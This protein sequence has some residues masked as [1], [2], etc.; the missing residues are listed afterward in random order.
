MTPAPRVYTERNAA[1]AFRECLGWVG[2]FRRFRSS[3]TG[4]DAR[5]AGMERRGSWWR[6]P[7][8]SRGIFH[9]QGRPCHGNSEG[10]GPEDLPRLC[11]C[12]ALHF[13]LR[14]PS[15]RRP[16]LGQGEV[17]WSG[18]RWNRK[19]NTNAITTTEVR[20]ARGCSHSLHSRWMSSGSRAKSSGS[21]SGETVHP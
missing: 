3:I 17:I 9:G 21:G 16:P 19:E 4:R 8:G 18:P 5:A 14:A 12:V 1:A 20:G 10:Q 11:E 13:S 15:A 6:E 2:S 7:G